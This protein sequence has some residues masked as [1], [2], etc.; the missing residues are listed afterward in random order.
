[1]VVKQVWDTTMAD[2]TSEDLAYF[3]RLKFA[4]PTKAGHICAFPLQHVLDWLLKPCGPPLI[5]GSER[6]VRGHVPHRA[7]ALLAAPGFLYS[8]GGTPL[9]NPMRGVGVLFIPPYVKKLS[10][11]DA[12]FFLNQWVRVGSEAFKE[13]QVI[14][15]TVLPRVLQ[16]L[17]YN[18]TLCGWI[19]PPRTLLR[20]HQDMFPYT[21]SEL[22]ASTG[23][24]Q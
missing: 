19:M 3:A 11:T 23:S 12:Y 10:F 4:V 13:E 14:F 2:Y 18:P 16:F 6:N 22:S 8:L 1:M 7:F 24:W 9:P 15:Y 20:R 5:E 21:V 17:S